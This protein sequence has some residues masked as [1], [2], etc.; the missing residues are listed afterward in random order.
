MVENESTELPGAPKPAKGGSAEF[1]R[2]AD[3]FT[4]FRNFYRMAT[5]SMSSQGKPDF[6]P[7]PPSGKLILHSRTKTILARRRPPLRI[8]RLPPLRIST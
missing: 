7:T 2:G 8:H 3:M 5:G 6:R 1:L 4:R